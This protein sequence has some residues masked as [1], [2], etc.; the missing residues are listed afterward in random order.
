MSKIVFYIFTAL[1]LLIWNVEAQNNY[2]IPGK[3]K[4]YNTPVRIAGLCLAKY[5]IFIPDGFPQLRGILVHQHGCGYACNNDWDGNRNGVENDIQYIALA[6]KWGF[7]LISP[8]L[9]QIKD[10]TIKYDRDIDC[11][12]WSNLENG[13]EKAFFA[14]LDTVARWSNHT[15][16]PNLP[17]ALWGHSGG[18]NW[19][20]SFMR[21]HPEK[22]IALF[23]VSPAFTYIHDYP[24]AVAKIPILIRHGGKADYNDNGIWCWKN[25]LRQF[26]LIREMGGYVGLAFSPKNEHGSGDSRYLAIPFFEAVFAQRLPVKGNTILQDMDTAKA[27]LADSTTNQLIKF[28]DY[29]GDKLNM[30]WL[31]DS[32]TAAKWK[33]FVSSGTVTDNTPPPAPYNIKISIMDTSNIE[34]SWNADADIESGIAHFNVYLNDKLIGQLPSE[35]EYQTFEY[36]DESVEVKPIPMKFDLNNIKFKDKAKIEV[37]TVNR[38]GLESMKSK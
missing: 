13:S 20:L 36:G 1:Y 15:E 19:V 17:I 11:L 7:A 22:I 26:H 4:V 16:I 28:S 3:G 18:G 30:V 8:S 14:A 37:T 12:G 21:K 34:I 5:A 27:W 2:L 38:S 9:C 25:A 33:E 24:K 29:K 10:S 31:P 23:A 32:I 6:K 35:K